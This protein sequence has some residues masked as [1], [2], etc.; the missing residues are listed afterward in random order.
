M[1][2]LYL[3][4][5][6]ISEPSYLYQTKTNCGKMAE[7]SRSWIERK[8]QLNFNSLLCL[9]QMDFKSLLFPPQ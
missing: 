9:V 3:H 6:C 7:Y 4:I 1:Q 2:D 8:R 5:I